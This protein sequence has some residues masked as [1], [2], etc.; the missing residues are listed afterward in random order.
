MAA[1][2]L[3]AS[4]IAT[5]QLVLFSASQSALGTQMSTA[6]TLAAKTV[7]SYRDRTFSSI[8]GGTTVTT[9]AVGPVTYTITTVTTVNDPAPNLTRV[10][11]TV[12]WGQ[13]SYVT[14]TILSPLGS[15]RSVRAP[16]TA[17]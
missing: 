6:A 9:S 5:S 1:T 16:L 2:L 4:L 7:E 17:A 13:Q 8:T 12:T 11:V 15:A 10:H 3:T 14:E